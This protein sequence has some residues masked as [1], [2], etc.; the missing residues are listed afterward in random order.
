MAADAGDKANTI[1]KKAEQSTTEFSSDETTRVVFMAG[2]E[3]LRWR[4]KCL[5]A[6]VVVKVGTLEGAQISFL[7]VKGAG[8]VKVA[9]LANQT[10]DPYSNLSSMQCLWELQFSCAKS[11]LLQI[12]G[13]KRQGENG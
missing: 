1:I 11:L 4:L 8:D 6:V 10:K 13:L 2:L 7:K 3:T 5:K 12:W 9:M